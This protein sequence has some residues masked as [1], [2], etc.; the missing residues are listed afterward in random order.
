MATPFIGEI[1][2]F[3]FTFAARNHAF[4]DGR[5]L[6]IAQ[7]TAL[8]S[9]LGTTYGGNGTTNFRIPD[10]RGRVAVHQGSGP[11]LSTFVIGQV[12]GTETVALATANLPSH[13]H[14]LRADSAIAPLSG[15]SPSNTFLANSAR[16]SRYATGTANSALSSQAINLQGSGTAHENMQPFLAL[17]Y[18]IALTGVFPSRS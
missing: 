3:G 6:N 11:G 14:A 9:L 16:T 18:C 17:N 4:C 15:S 2:T 8:F 12:S 10:L 1:K 7:N 13:T 5:T